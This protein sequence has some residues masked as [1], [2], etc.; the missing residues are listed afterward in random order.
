VLSECRFTRVSVT[1]SSFR[2]TRFSESEFVSLNAPV[3]SAPLSTWRDVSISGSRIG[4]AEVFES[5]FSGVR[6]E[7]SKL[8]YLNLRGAKLVNVVISG[9]TID[10]LDLGHATAKRVAII[11]CTIGTLDVTRATLTDVD[12]R[13]STFQSL[14]GLPGLRGATI[15]DD[16]LASLAPHLAASIGLRIEG[17][18]IQ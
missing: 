10:E 1:D 6:I 11:D 8:G 14:T 4:S 15:D 18:G 12:L 7:N 2:C 17:C 16:Q 3:L 5:E 13:G 9:C